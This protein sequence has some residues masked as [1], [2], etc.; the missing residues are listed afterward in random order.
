MLTSQ[1]HFDRLPRALEPTEANGLPKAKG[2]PHV[3]PK[4]HGPRGHCPPCPPLGGPSQTLILILE[5]ATKN[6]RMNMTYCLFS[7]L[8]LLTKN[9]RQ[10]THS[11]W[12]KL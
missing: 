12:C 1:C 8:S 10:N 2:P 5:K 4:V 7:F 11:S 9:F 6:A 3:P